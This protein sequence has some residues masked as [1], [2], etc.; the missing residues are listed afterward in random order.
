MN[1]VWF[2]YVAER[3]AT[4]ASGCEIPPLVLPCTQNAN[5]LRSVVSDWIVFEV[6]KQ[7]PGQGR[8]RFKGCYL[9][10]HLWQFGRGGQDERVRAGKFPFQQLENISVNAERVGVNLCER[11][12]ACAICRVQHVCVCV[13]ACACVCVCVCVCVVGGY[14]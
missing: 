11:D 3:D 7:M 13:C 5:L 1:F 14:Y 6:I 10:N 9:V 4:H 8:V 2:W 12:R